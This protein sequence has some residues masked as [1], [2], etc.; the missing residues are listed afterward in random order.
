V[1]PISGNT[2]QGTNACLKIIYPSDAIITPK[3]NLPVKGVINHAPSI[4]FLPDA[5]KAKHLSTRREAIAKYNTR[6]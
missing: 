6:L 3:T 2:V 4:L 5:K 1:C